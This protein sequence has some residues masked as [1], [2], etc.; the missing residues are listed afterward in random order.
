[1]DPR[2]YRYVLWAMIGNEKL[3]C[4]VAKDRLTVRVIKPVHAVPI[5]MSM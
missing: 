5:D 1:M 3:T 4:S 2:A